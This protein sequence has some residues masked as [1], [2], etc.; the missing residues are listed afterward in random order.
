M[1]G[2]PGQ[3]NSQ[4]SSLDILVLQRGKSGSYISLKKL[5]MRKTKHGANNE[6]LYIDEKAFSFS[7]VKAF[8]SLF[9]GL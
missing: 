5:W 2:N 6:M 3:F 4:K 8:V 1:Y 7:Y 9:R